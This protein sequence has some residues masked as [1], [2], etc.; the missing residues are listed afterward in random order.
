MG[1]RHDDARAR[2]RTRRTARWLRIR[3]QARADDPDGA[4][5][6]QRQQH[7]RAPTRHRRS[8]LRLVRFEI[9]R[10]FRRSRELAELT[11]PFRLTTGFRL[12]RK[13][14][15]ERFLVDVE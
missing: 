6:G 4:N 12:E 10:R 2:C 14:L 7:S 5:G 9:V 3:R 1:S 13:R 8:L 15:E 11:V